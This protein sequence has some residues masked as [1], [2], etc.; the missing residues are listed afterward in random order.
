[1]RRLHIAGSAN[2]NADAK[3]LRDAHTVASEIAYGWV[4]KGG[5]LVGGLGGEPMSDDQA[6]LSIIFDWT[7]AEA[8]YAALAAGVAQARTKAGQLLAVRTSRRALEQVPDRRRGL[9]DALLDRR[10]I[11]IKLLPDGWRSGALMRRAQA[12]IGGVL[13]TLSGGAGVEDLVNLYVDH[14]RPIVPV[15][16]DLGS[17]NSDAAQ[18]GGTGL[19]RKALADPRPFLRLADG[20]P[21]GARLLEVSMGAGRLSAAQVA[22]RLL[23]LLADLDPPRAFCVRLLAPNHEDFD[24]VEWFFG[25]A[26]KPV[27]AESGFRAVDLGTD[28]QERAWMNDEIFAALHHAE[29]VVADL[30]AARPNCLLELGYSLGRGHRTLVTAREG[31]SMP[32]D[33][34]KL[35]W[36][37]WKRDDTPEVA[38]DALRDYLR[39]F[40]MR[41]PL[42]E[43]TRLV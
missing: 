4:S 24:D 3:L 34:D 20:G 23:S 17:A 2:R 32:F 14:D 36:L 29:L 5:T 33:A 25:E 8:V 42:V 1:M 43:T 13:V 21:P 11:D 15:D 16:I 35:P 31:E 30:T 9:L 10:A 7:I 39:R 22:A 19:A 18:G 26:V 28:P 12:E 27:L 37:F 38:R 40:S 41:A 6:E